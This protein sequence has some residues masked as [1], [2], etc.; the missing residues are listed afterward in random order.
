MNFVFGAG[1][2]LWNWK[3]S[4]FN[5]FGSFYCAHRI[6]TASISKHPNLLCTQLWSAYFELVFAFGMPITRALFVS[7]WCAFDAVWLWKHHKCDCC[8]FFSLWFLIKSSSVYSWKPCMAL[9]FQW[10]TKVLEFC[11]TYCTEQKMAL[12]IQCRDALL[13]LIHAD[14]HC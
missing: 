14:M 8:L 2:T 11:V 4:S 1:Q 10:Q 12:C 6:A 5:L 13:S 3:Q 7:F 9:I